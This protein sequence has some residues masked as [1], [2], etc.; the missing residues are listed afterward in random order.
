MINSETKLF[1]IAGKPVLHSKSP[2][3]FNGLFEA[4]KLNNY[5]LKITA[6]DAEG[7]LSLSKLLGLS[8]I[9]ITAP[10]KETFMGLGVLADDASKNIGACNTIRFSE[11]K[12]ESFNFDSLGVVK[13]IK[14]KI[15]SLKGINAL[16]I[17]AGG[18]AKAAVFGLIQ[19]G[20]HVSVSNRT[21]QNAENIAKIFPICI[22][23]PENIPSVI[24]DFN[25]IVNT[26]EYPNSIFDISI[27]QKGQMVLDANY[28]NSIF[29][30][31]C[32]LHDIP[33]IDGFPWLI[34]QATCSF[35]TFTGLSVTK[36]YISNHFI[37]NSAKKS[38]IISFIG[39]S[40]SGKSSLGEALAKSLNWN[41]L[42]TDSEI[43]KIFGMS[44]TNIF[45][46][47]GETEFRNAESKLLE[48]L[49]GAKNLVISTGGGFILKES[50]RK[51]LKENSLVINLM[52]DFETLSN[53]ITSNNRP[54]LNSNSL[55]EDLKKMFINRKQFYLETADLVFYNQDILMD[56]V[57]QILTS[58]VFN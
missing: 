29:K 49:V 14:E 44:I 51:C 57:T 21:V 27:L 12:M 56:E 8:G 48:S 16:V 20:A 7:I 32:N 39:L 2:D 35:E 58:E 18:A 52:A 42:D 11:Q 19:E 41:F 6:K 54:L 17:G 13:S 50:N 40:G 46:Q 33:F 26:I 38:D 22:V 24:N 25:L 55:E 43:E 3:I 9:N 30:E 47:H 34:H 37:Q 10:Y 31:F 36:E 45:K 23:L 1:A 5:Y 28:K 15:N 4:N 53:R